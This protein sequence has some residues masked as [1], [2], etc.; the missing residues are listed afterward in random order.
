MVD[1][2][3]NQWCVAWQIVKCF[4]FTLDLQPY[5][6]FLRA[7]KTLN[8]LSFEVPYIFHLSVKMQTLGI[9]Y[10]GIVAR[11]LEERRHHSL[12]CMK[13]NI[14][15]SWCWT[16]TGD[17]SDCK[18]FHLATPLSRYFIGRWALLTKI[19]KGRMGR[20]GIKSWVV[21][22][23]LYSFSSTISYL[24]PYTWRESSSALYILTIISLQLYILHWNKKNC[25]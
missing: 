20:P 8:I 13:T 19:C 12:G 5:M 21:S 4:I 1:I 7:F 25:L 23:N 11:E 6:N 22:K 15:I 14:D 24:F 3:L 17:R 2:P 16:R 9:I 18:I 10:F